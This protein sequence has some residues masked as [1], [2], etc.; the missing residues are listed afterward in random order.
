M[1]E[2]KDDL[3][4]IPKE[5]NVRITLL[6]GD[7]AEV[8]KAVGES[9]TLEGNLSLNESA[10]GYEVEF[11]Y[12]Q[13]EQLL[14]ELTEHVLAKIDKGEYPK[15]ELW[16]AKDVISNALIGLQEERINRLNQGEG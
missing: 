9:S 5:M 6:A 12:S 3:S 11:T 14:K 2:R 4:S 16:R 1:A 13:W 7:L 10:T 15:P 8:Y